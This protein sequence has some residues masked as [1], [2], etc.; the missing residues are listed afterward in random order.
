MRLRKAFASNSSESGLLLNS[1]RET[2]R[3]ISL[4]VISHICAS[5]IRNLLVGKDTIRADEGRIKASLSAIR[6][7]QD[8]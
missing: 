7:G 4:Y 1:V 5:L 3:R 6:A 8:F 2:K